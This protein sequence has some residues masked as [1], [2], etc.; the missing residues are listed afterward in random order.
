MTTE[1]QYRKTSNYKVRFPTIVHHARRHQSFVANSSEI[2][3]GHVGDTLRFTVFCEASAPKGARKHQTHTNDPPPN[4][5]QDNN[6]HGNAASEGRTHDLRITRPT[7]CQASKETRD[8]KEPEPRLPAS[9][10]WPIGLRRWLKAPLRKGAGSN[11]TA[12]IFTKLLI[13][14]TY[15][16]CLPSD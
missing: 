9:T 4:K 14:Q 2:R 8:L 16:Q 15:L 1:K 12:V 3:A 5:K 11:P 6:I 7:R 10:V 13:S